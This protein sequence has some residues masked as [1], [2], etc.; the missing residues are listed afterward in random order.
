M[1][2]FNKY[3]NETSYSRKEHDKMIDFAEDLARYGDDL[4]K[5]ISVAKFNENEIDNRSMALYKIRNQAK[6]PKFK[7]DV[8]DVFID[9]LKDISESFWTNVDT[10]REGT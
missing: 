2:R 5:I 3:L 6:S 8:V 1:P 4:K 10:S 7:N 9:Y